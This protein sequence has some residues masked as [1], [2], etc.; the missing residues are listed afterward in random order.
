MLHDL[1][2]AFLQVA[3]EGVDVHIARGVLL[4]VLQHRG[5]QG[6]NRAD[7]AA[8]QVLE[9]ID[10]GEALGSVIATVSTPWT[11]SIQRREGVRLPPTRRV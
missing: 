3:E 11:L 1:D 5:F 7:L 10:R 8:G 6:K 9:S 2:I 4:D